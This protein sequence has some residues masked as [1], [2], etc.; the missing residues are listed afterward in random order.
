MSE[1]RVE[2]VLI[3]ARGGAGMAMLRAIEAGG[4]EGVLLMCD[5]DAHQAWIDE[6]AYVVHVPAAADG[7]WPDWFKVASVC[8]DAGCDA[9]LPAT[10]ALAA[11]VGLA[12]RLSAMNAG[13]LGPGREGLALAADWVGFLDRARA[14]SI[15]VVPAIDL[16]DD[17][18][19]A[20]AE[21]EG[22]LQRWGAP[23]WL[24]VRRPDG[25][26]ETRRLRALEGAR[27]ELEAAFALG[28]LSLLHHP[29]NARVI[30]VPV[31]G[32]GNGQVVALGDREVTVWREGQGVLVEA[33]AADL[34]EALRGSMAE[35][36]V[37]V[38]SAMRWRGIGALTFALTADGRA[39]L[40]ELK[41]G[42]QPWYSATEAAYGVDLLDAIIR[43]AEGQALGWSAED[44]VPTGAAMV[45]RLFVEA[46]AP[47]PEHVSVAPTGPRPDEDEYDEEDEADRPGVA[48][49][50]VSLPEDVTV[51]LPLFVGD[52]VLPGEELGLILVTA[53][54]RQSCIVR[55]KAALD[56][57]DIGGVVHT[58][59]IL[60]EVLSTAD[61]WRG[62]AGGDM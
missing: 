28:K 58:G 57:V 19:R 62:P 47:L 6:V 36:A 34:P 30:E 61:Y 20:L 2:R 3:G 43:L 33:P 25:G 59:A 44:V 41:P 14:A 17:L 10:P 9:V 49:A 8:L 24:R 18:E 55:A 31:I 38:L 60:A 54:T 22:W 13:E 39:F 56:H 50:S 53:P 23:A 21:G 12:E 15:R 11:H 51:D 40:R 52:R 7:Q 32:D 45:L 1:R 48:V 4:R 42:L 29:P 27:A 26:V 46:A 35:D 37:K 16:G 5:Q